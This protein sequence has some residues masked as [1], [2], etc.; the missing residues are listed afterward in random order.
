M[1]AE[2]LTRLLH[3]F[4]T[5]DQKYSFVHAF[6]H[7]QADFDYKRMLDSMGHDTAQLPRD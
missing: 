5:Q 2:Q 1:Q 3:D 7:R 6:N 4:Y